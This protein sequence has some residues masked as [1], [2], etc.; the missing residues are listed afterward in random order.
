M[1]ERYNDVYYNTNGDNT[2]GNMNFSPYGQ[3]WVDPDAAHDNPDFVGPPYPGSR[4]SMAQAKAVSP[5]GMSQAGSSKAKWSRDLFLEIVTEAQIRAA[6]A[7]F[8]RELNELE[9][10]IIKQRVIGV[11]IR[12]EPEFSFKEG[13]YLEDGI[14]VFKCQRIALNSRGQND[15]RVRQIPPMDCYYRTRRKDVRGNGERSRGSCAGGQTSSDLPYSATFVADHS[16]EPADKMFP[17][18][19]VDV[20]CLRSYM[21]CGTPTGPWTPLL[22]DCNTFVASALEN[23]TAK[24]RVINGRWVYSVIER[25]KDGSLQIRKAEGLYYESRS[26]VKEKMGNLLFMNKASLDDIADILISD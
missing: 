12:A 3:T 13:D 25:A 5:Q 15:S 23:S 11:G 8:G 9:T 26:G 20:K 16:K 1:L 2:P 4:P 7:A 19:G 14:I 22:N 21:V 24:W 10:L 18:H 6:T 17:Q